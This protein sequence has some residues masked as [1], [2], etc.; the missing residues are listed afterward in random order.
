M[1]FWEDEQSKRF[2]DA[3]NLFESSFTS[4][5]PAKILR[6]YACFLN[7]YKAENDRLSA[8]PTEPRL[9]T[10]HLHLFALGMFGHYKF[11]GGYRRSTI[12][13]R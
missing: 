2:T 7:Y 9:L 6:F 8:L 12:P 10:R 13:L 5:G 4:K 1:P 11:E 3:Q